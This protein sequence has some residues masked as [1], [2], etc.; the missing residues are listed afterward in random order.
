MTKGSRSSARRLVERRADAAGR[1]TASVPTAFPDSRRDR[2]PAAEAS[3]CAGQRRRQPHGGDDLDM[4]AAAAEVEAQRLADFGL[5]RIRIGVD[6]RAGGHDH[7][8]E[9]IAALRGV[10]GDEGLLHGIKPVARGQAL[11]RRHGAGPRRR[12]ASARRR[13]Q[14]VRRSARCRRRIRRGRSHISAR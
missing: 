4:R 7:A 14:A 13:G 3:S 10:A 6:Q 8:V 2:A 5:R 9:A 11:E 12:R 1:T